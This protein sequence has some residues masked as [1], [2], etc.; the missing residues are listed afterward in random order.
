MSY[1][2][3]PNCPIRDNPDN[4]EHCITCGN[5]LCVA[6]RYWLVKPLRDLHHS[7]YLEVFEVR[8][9]EAQTSKVLKSLKCNLSK[10]R[11]LFEQEAQILIELNHSGILKT[12]PSEFFTVELNNGQR[13][14]CLVMEFVEGQ[15]LEKWVQKNGSISQNL[16]LEWLKQLTE[17]L[18]YVHQ[19]NFFHRD[20]K[21][22]NIMRKPNGQLVLIDF[23]TAREVTTTVVEGREVTAVY[24]HGYT[25]PEQIEGKAVP[26]SDFFSLGCTFVYLLTGKHPQEFNDSQTRQLNWRDSIPDISELL[27]NFIDEL[28][29][30]D[31]E[32]RPQNTQAIL[33]RIEQIDRSL[34][35]SDDLPV[36]ELPLPPQPSRLPW[37]AISIGLTISSILLGVWIG[38]NIDR[39]F[40]P[41]IS[42][43]QP[44]ASPADD[45]SAIAF[46]PNGKFL[47]TVSLDKTVRVL[48]IEETKSEEVGCKEHQDGV[49]A[50]QFS[51]DGTKFATASLDSTVGLGKIN[52]NGSI[53]SFKR[54]Q[55]NNNSFPAVAIA[56]SP[57]AKYLATAS[58]DGTVQVWD[59]KQAKEIAL[60]KP[61][62]Y[63]KNIS[64]SRD[65]KYLA[66]ASLNDKVRV[67]EWQ[68]HSYDQK[69]ISLPAENVTDVAFSPMD[70]NYLS[71]ASADGTVRIW[72][73]T[74][75]EEVACLKDK[76]YV[77]AISFSPDG[78][79]LAAV[80][81]NNEARIW[82]WKKYRDGQN[83]T[84]QLKGVAIAVFSPKDGKYLATINSDG[85]ARVRETDGALNRRIA[86]A[87]LLEA[88]A[89]NPADENS[90]ALARIDGT[91]E[92]QQWS[93]QSQ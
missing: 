37:L 54:L 39:W 49:V 57:D 22:S 93:V 21:P 48:A 9:R 40:A 90:L 43:S 75:N 78:R 84:R 15:D 82:E 20:I 35:H 46:S 32:N 10:Y 25:A 71:V 87:N 34:S 26:K 80:S 33:Q 92:I 12:Q 50:V 29:A 11:E 7:P 30:S 85:T 42:L 31:V 67:W 27:T 17:I 81:L 18:A 76:A 8:D 28:R 3:N 36:T 44:C 64:F 19:H 66:T 59:A 24:S 55:Q 83:L 47:A 86:D 2:I 62:I 77:M 38:R 13:L 53:S 68:A 45:I 61:K 73:M 63:V 72:D 41:A 79:Y 4:V 69:T 60:L 91:I 70:E 89:F 6:N 23:G 88:V 74:K 65:G 16:A 56:F 52:S 58:A 5:L 1:C 51:P 14:P